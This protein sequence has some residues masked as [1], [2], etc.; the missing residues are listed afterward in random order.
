V[1][2]K[3]DPGRHVTSSI[4]LRFEVE[5]KISAEQLHENSLLYRDRVL[6]LT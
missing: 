3:T 1:R 5:G 2:A 4:A 6:A